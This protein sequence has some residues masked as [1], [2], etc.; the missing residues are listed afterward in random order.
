M[1][2]LSTTLQ[3]L[4]GLGAILCLLKLRQLS[5]AADFFGCT[6]S[7]IL[8][9]AHV[10]RWFNITGYVTVATAI[11]LGFQF[12]DL[13]CLSGLMLG[14]LVILQGQQLSGQRFEYYDHSFLG[15]EW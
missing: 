10:Q 9:T 11:L 6:A 12:E 8:N 14:F 5:L 4:S 1:L 13:H 3:I 2:A 15:I 7:E